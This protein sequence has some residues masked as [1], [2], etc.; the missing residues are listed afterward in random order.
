MIFANTISITG[1]GIS[2]PN[3]QSLST[4]IVE[5][6]MYKEKIPAFVICADCGFASGMT[7]VTGYKAKE[8]AQKIFVEGTEKW[9]KYLDEHLQIVDTLS[10]EVED[11]HQLKLIP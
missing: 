6:K 9:E 11:K 1:A 4:E 10:Q 7:G 3:C 8:I 2:C 5:P